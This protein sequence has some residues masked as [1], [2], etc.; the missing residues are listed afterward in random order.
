MKKIFA[1]LI[2]SALC[3]V[4]AVNVG[5]DQR[6]GLAIKTE[7][8]M[9]RHSIASVVGGYV[10]SA[11][12]TSTLVAGVD[13]TQTWSPA[14][15]AQVGNTLAGT[16]TAYG[17][18]KAFITTSNTA[19]DTM[20]LYIDQSAD[21]VNWTAASSAINMLGGGTTKQLFV[22]LPLKLD[23]AATAANSWGLAPFIRFRV[24]SDNNTVATGCRFYISYFSNEAN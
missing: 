13:T 11:T 1:A 3:V 22:P 17:A 10:D 12:T 8:L 14:L 20:F 16:A 24:Q 21:G 23:A 15:M 9:W 6:I 18:A 19:G 2:L 5:A 4:A 7:N